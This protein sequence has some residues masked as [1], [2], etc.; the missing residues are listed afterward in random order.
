M[1]SMNGSVSGPSS[2]TMNGTR[3][4]IRPAMNATSRLSLSSFATSTGHFRRFA[5]ARAAASCGELRP[6]VER[7]GSLAGLDLDVFAHD[8]D[9]L[10]LT[11]PLNSGLLR[12]KPQAGAPLPGRRN[13]H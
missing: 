1:C 2:A 9:A 6:S 12:L 7:V 3:C 5:S 4:A 10:G 8:L 13:A 11:E